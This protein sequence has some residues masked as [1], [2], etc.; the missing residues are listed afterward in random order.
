MTI[1]A[2][3]IKR[4]EELLKVGYGEDVAYGKAVIEWYEKFFEKAK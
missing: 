4:Y 3:V 2:Y 1:K